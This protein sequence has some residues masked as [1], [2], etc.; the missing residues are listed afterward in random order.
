MI[1]HI[2]R[3]ISELKF[4]L[5]DMERGMDPDDEDNLFSDEADN[6]KV[7][8]SNSALTRQPPNGK[9]RKN[10]GL[11]P[12]DLSITA[13][14]VI[15]VNSQVENFSTIWVNVPQTQVKFMSVTSNSKYSTLDLDSHA[16]T[17]VLGANAL[18]IQDHVRPVNVLS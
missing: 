6:I 11:W 3:K 12:L 5:R 9:R 4:T 18:V 17:C 8:I 14:A 2:K 7:N 10:G 1:N 16:D 13:N 15:N